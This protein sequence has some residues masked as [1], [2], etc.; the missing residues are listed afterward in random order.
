M[1]ISTARTPSRVLNLSAPLSR[2]AIPLI[3]NIPI[4]NKWSKK[5]WFTATLNHRM[6]IGKILNKRLNG[7]TE[8][9]HWMLP[10]EHHDATSLI[11]CKGCE[12]TTTL[13]HT[14]N[15]NACSIIVAL[16]SNARSINRVIHHKGPNDDVY[17]LKIPS[18]LLTHRSH[19]SASLNST[20]TSPSPTVDD[21]S[22]T[23]HSTSEFTM[24]PTVI[25][26]DPDYDHI[27]TIADHDTADTL[28]CILYKLKSNLTPCDHRSP[29]DVTPSTH[30]E[31]YTDG[32]C[33]LNNSINTMGSGWTIINV[34]PHITFKCKIQ[35]WPS[36]TRAELNAIWTFLL[37]IPNNSSANVYTDSQAAIYSIN[38][39]SCI[40]NRN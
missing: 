37:A 16:P 8:F 36:S 14:H 35:N 38:K 6:I 18:Q 11:K 24:N 13:N 20:V 34:T 27:R 19:V 32:S 21:R 25:I 39:D 28:T 4:S 2:F 33:D 15:P 9:A 10:T 26:T 22:H 40:S 23:S 29:S 1:I 3:S 30:Y 12:H 7:T 5:E 31:V 17:M